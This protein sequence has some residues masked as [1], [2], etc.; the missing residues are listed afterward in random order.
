M[1]E[2][3]AVN[4]YRARSGRI[5]GKNPLDPIQQPAAYTEFRTLPSFGNYLS[6]C[7][8]PAVRVRRLL[9]NLGLAAA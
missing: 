8:K 6:A 5:A 9:A 4:R 1:S 2:G 7:D 3:L